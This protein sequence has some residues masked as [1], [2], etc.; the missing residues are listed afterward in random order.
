M[1]RNPLDQWVDS[2]RKAD[3]AKT[4]FGVSAAMAL[5]V[6]ILIAL[7]LA[8]GGYAQGQSPLQPLRNTTTPMPPM[9][10]FVGDPWLAFEQASSYYQGHA[11]YTLFC[12]GDFVFH[13]GGSPAGFRWLVG[14]PQRQY[15]LVYSVAGDRG[16]DVGAVVGRISGAAC[17]PMVYPYRQARVVSTFV[18]N[19]PPAD[20][21]GVV[22]TRQLLGAMVLVKYRIYE[23][24]LPWEF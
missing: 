2:E 6:V 4:V 13:A 19:T 1:K 10:S 12:E 5:A 24:R 17:E 20:A 15:V 16:Q 21:F 7:W 11:R 23:G 18:V 8:L 3:L 22:F 14:D 9:D